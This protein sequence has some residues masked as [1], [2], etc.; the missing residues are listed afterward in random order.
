MLRTHAPVSRDLSRDLNFDNHQY[1]RRNLHAPYRPLL[2]NTS[3][4]KRP[5]WALQSIAYMHMQF[6]IFRLIGKF[7]PTYIH[8]PCVVRFLVYIRW[9]ANKFVRKRFFVKKWNFL[10][11][12]PWRI[13]PKGH[14]RFQKKKKKIRFPFSDFHYSYP[15]LNIASFESRVS[16]LGDYKII[17]ITFFRIFRLFRFSFFLFGV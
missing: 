9:P 7:T 3:P 2:P 4:L 12:T 6:G 11:K 13:C 15:V 1:I 10:Y 16:N 8:W 5:P 17:S 14:S